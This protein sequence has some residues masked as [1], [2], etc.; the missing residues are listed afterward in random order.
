[1]YD[2]SL[3]CMCN[4]QADYRAVTSISFSHTNRLLFSAHDN[5]AI[6]AWDV[7]KVGHH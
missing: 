6:L 4:E 1:M 5:Y 7:L 3:V 2:M